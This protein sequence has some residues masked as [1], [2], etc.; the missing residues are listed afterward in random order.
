MKFLKNSLP[1]ILFVLFEI[2]VGVML[3]VN[4]E[5]FTTS[6]III[7]GALLV[8]F[9]AIYLVKYLLARRKQEQSTLMLVMSLVAV[10]LGVFA[11]ICAQFIFT[12][13]VFIA[14]MYAIIM[15]ISGL[16]K[17]QNYVHAKKEELPSSPITVISAVI[18]VI[19]GVIVV[20]NPFGTTHV[21]WVFVGIMIL[22]EALIDIV[23]LILAARTWKDQPENEV[24]E[25]VEYQDV[26]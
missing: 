11:I 20:L 12:L 15:L 9:G 7:F 22:V 8:I 2:V 26:E 4:P 14:V 18:S 3:L 1:T 6:V 5:A 16:F 23:S 17:I 13:F 19:L 24:I 21:L 10:S 25:I